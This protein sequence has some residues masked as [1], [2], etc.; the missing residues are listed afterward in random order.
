[1]QDGYATATAQ[2]G[3]ANEVLGLT[4]YGASETRAYNGL[5]Q[6]TRQTVAGAMDMQY[7][8]TAGQNNG[9]IAS[10]SSRHP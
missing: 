10:T 1:M 7:V 3:P 8:Y 9:R 6:M 2:Y 4:Y 5:L